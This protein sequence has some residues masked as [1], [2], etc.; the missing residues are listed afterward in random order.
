MVWRKNSRA[1]KFLFSLGLLVFVLTVSTLQL[2]AQKELSTADWEEI[3]KDIDYG[4]KKEKAEEDEEEVEEAAELSNSGDSF[5]D[6]FSG[7]STSPFVSALLIGL[8]SILLILL[9]I[10]LISIA[11]RDRA[12]AQGSSRNLGFNLDEIEEN[13]QE[14]DLERALRLALEA[15]DYKV[16]L[17]IYYLSIIKTMN[18]QSLIRYKKEKTNFDYVRELQEAQLQSHFSAITISFERIWYGNRSIGL[19]EYTKLQPKFE[20]FINQLDRGE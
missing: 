16:A 15:K 9:I 6:I 1:L 10:Y 18:A 5:W 11:Q 3:T 17:R 19:E 7:I 12:L 13:I 14:S 20:Q 8:A 2:S 4:E